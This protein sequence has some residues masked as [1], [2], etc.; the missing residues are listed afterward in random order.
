MR[1][2]HAL[3]Y[4]CFGLPFRDVAAYHYTRHGHTGSL[5]SLPHRASPLNQAIICLAGPAGEAVYTGE[6]LSE[7]LDDDCTDL[8]MAQDARR[9]DDHL[10][11]A[12][13][14]RCANMRVSMQ[15]TRIGFAADALLTAEQLSYAEVVRVLR[16]PETPRPG[17]GWSPSVDRP[18][19]G[20]RYTH[21]LCSR[22]AARTSSGRTDT[23]RC[24]RN[25][26]CR[27]L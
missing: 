27:G 14:L 10:D 26:D 6:P 25:A 19:L 4:L 24:A 9:R 7:V 18:A 3:A 15:W 20:R 5:H 16:P 22:R 21:S 11:L 2:G 13:A 8:L 1:S 23:C 17:A 12:S